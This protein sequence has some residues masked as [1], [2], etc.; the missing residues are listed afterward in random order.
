MALGKC[1]HE[2]CVQNGQ[3]DPGD[4][5]KRLQASVGSLIFCW[6]RLEDAVSE[7]LRAA[8]GGE[9]PKVSVPF[10]DQLSQ[11]NRLLEERWQEQ[12]PLK[13]ALSDLMARIEG[14][15]HRRN[16][17]VHCFAGASSEP[18]NGEPHIICRSQ[19]RGGLKST[20]ITQSELSA[21]LQQID[22][23][24]CDVTSLSLGFLPLQR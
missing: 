3:L 15:R 12:E 17:I 8:R 10:H 21:L 20:K 1:W 24:R 5:F 4:A 6:C 2:T 14:L 22:R 16:L 9:S 7:G 11:L 23:C 18:W 19:V 13:A